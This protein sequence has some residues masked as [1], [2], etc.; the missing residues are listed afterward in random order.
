[1]IYLNKFGDEKNFFLREGDKLEIITR[2]SLYCSIDEEPN[3]H[4]GTLKEIVFKE[5]SDGTIPIGLYVIFNRDH[6][7][8]EQEEEFVLLADIEDVFVKK[9]EILGYGILNE[10]VKLSV[11]GEGVSVIISYSYNDGSLIPDGISKNEDRP[12][13]PVKEDDKDFIREIGKYGA[14]QKFKHYV[15]SKSK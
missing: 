7:Y 9:Y 2:S 8:E 12:Y 1:M 15:L 14:A 6:L 13:Q 10:G 5:F 4:T 3:Y 11:K